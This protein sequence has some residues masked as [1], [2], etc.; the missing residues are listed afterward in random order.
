M[1]QEG[2]L[3]SLTAVRTVSLDFNPAD[4]LS[5]ESWTETV[6]TKPLSVGRVIEHQVDF[7]EAAQ[8]VGTVE[9]QN[10]YRLK[11]ELE[12]TPVGSNLYYEDFYI[13]EGGKLYIYSPEG[14]QILGAYTHAT[15]PEHGAFATEPIRGNTLI[16][17]YEA[18]VT[19]EMPAIKVQ[20]VGYFYRPVL[21]ADPGAEHHM[22]SEDGADPGFARY[23]QINANCPEGDPYQDQKASSVAMLMVGGRGIGFCSGNLVNNVAGDFKPYVMSA[24]HCASVTDKFEVSP[25]QLNQWIFSFH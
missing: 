17:D 4:Y 6:Q 9:G 10:I 11:I 12:G 25:L 1:M 14:K 22:S 7:A 13:P 16:L 2:S 19:G 24:A 3:R 23:C 8:L 15:H 21:M 20:G 5:Q 18:P